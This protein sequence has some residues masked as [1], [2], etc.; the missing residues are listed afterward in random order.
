MTTVKYPIDEISDAVFSTMYY[1]NHTSSSIEIVKLN[2]NDL[3]SALQQNTCC[4]VMNVNVN[5]KL[6]QRIRIVPA[7][8]IYPTLES[9]AMSIQQEVSKAS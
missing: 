1:V 5:G 6:I 9:A 4:K 3:V 2:A 8:Y 7:Q